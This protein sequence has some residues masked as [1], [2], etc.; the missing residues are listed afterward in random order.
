[1]ILDPYDWDNIP[2]PLIDTNVIRELPARTA[3]TAPN[4]EW[5]S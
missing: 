2:E 3:F 5:M 1:M 4:E